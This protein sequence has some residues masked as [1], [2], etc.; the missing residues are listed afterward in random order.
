VE[1]GFDLPRGRKGRPRI[2]GDDAILRRLAALSEP[3][4]T[5]MEIRDNRA[6]VLI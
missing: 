1:L 5:R 6:H 4:G 3:Y 2:A